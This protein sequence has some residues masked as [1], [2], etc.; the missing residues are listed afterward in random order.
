[1]IGFGARL[2][3]QK[4]PEDVIRAAALIVP[5]Y[6][7]AAFVIAGEGSRR[8]EY[9]ALA[10]SLGIAH[11]VRFVGYVRRHAIVLRVG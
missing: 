4:R 9:E 2:A 6:P 1:M 3:P 8:A 10:R 7:D 5:A 11:A